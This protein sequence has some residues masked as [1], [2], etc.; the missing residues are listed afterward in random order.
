MQEDKKYNS[1][2]KFESIASIIVI[3]IGV[4]AFGYGIISAINHAVQNARTN[5]THSVSKSQDTISFHTAAKM[6]Q[7]SR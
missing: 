2:D 4:G 1:Y 3:L 7:K 6:Q 5:A